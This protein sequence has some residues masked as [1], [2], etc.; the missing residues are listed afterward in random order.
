MHIVVIGWKDQA[1]LCT[2]LQRAYDSRGTGSPIMIGSRIANGAICDER[3]LFGDATARLVG[4][5]TKD[6]N[7]TWK[8]P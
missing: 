8:L 3:I 6:G 5:L 1:M 7:K 2:N 4:D